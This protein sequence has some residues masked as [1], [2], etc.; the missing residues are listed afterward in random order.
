MAIEFKAT[1]VSNDSRYPNATIIYTTPTITEQLGSRTRISIKGT[2][3]KTAFTG[4]LFPTGQGTHYLVVNKKLR[5]QAG[6]KSGD[7]VFLVIEIDKSPQRPEVPADLA[8]ALEKFPQAKKKFEI[9]SP[10]HQK[11]YA[12]YVDEAKK[13]ETK[14]RR[15]AK[16]IKMLSRSENEYHE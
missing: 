9:L 14:K 2:I 5:E 8:K 12:A 10:S 13:E 15:I 4:S 7:T 1:L 16:V 3:N 6:V 11:E